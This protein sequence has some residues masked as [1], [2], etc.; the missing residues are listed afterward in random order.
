MPELGPRFVPIDAL[1]QYNK[2]YMA[3]LWLMGEC[4]Q[5]EMMEAFNIWMSDVFRGVNGNL[6]EVLDEMCLCELGEDLFLAARE[7]GVS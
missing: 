3:Q 6:D 4:P 5:G 1:P 7:R 2:H